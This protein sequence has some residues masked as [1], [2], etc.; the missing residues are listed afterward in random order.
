LRGR[1]QAAR[2]VL[3]AMRASGMYLS[4][5]VLSQALALVGE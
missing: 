5:G 4:D 2:P 1:I 3:Q